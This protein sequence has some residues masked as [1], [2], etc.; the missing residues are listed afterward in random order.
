M[1]HRRDIIAAIGALGLLLG[2][3]GGSSHP[4]ASTTATQGS[5]GATTASTHATTQATTRSAAVSA[6]VPSRHP[7]AGGPVPKSFDP[8]AFTA[9]SPIQFWLLG[10]APCSR[11]VCTSIVR[12]TDGGAH[13][14]GIPAPLAPI[15]SPTTGRGV[16]TLLF[17]DP[18]DGFAGGRDSPSRA[19]CG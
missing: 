3:C 14:V 11:P 9:I 5:S 16:S 12:T 15:E 7:P 8:V 13:F 2:G 10:T 4:T 19:S 1:T 6:P 17:A 18:L